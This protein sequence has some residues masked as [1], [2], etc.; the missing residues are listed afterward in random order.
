MT[1]YDY[2]FSEVFPN[3]GDVS[4][5]PML[6]DIWALGIILFIVLTGVPP[7][8]SAVETDERYRTIAEGRLREMVEDWG[9]ILSPASLDL[10][11]GILRPDP[12][13]RLSLTQIL[14]HPWMTQQG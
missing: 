6:N 5:N 2:S 9:F 10:L 4:F 12:R 8:D 11:Q 7:V 13:Q 3:Q 1:V 14:N